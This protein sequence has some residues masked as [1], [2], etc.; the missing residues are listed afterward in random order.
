MFEAMQTS[1]LEKKQRRWE[2]REMLFNIKQKQ[3]EDK[4]KQEHNKPSFLKKL[5]QDKEY[6]S[7]TCFWKSS[8]KT[9]T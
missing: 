4:M 6:V 7:G 8:N 3:K 9:G 5:K 2:D 1:R